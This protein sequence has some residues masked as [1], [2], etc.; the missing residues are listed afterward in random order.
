MAV[1]H[2]ISKFYALVDININVSRERRQ[3]IFKAAKIKILIFIKCL[4]RAL[5]TSQILNLYNNSVFSI[6]QVIPSYFII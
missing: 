6:G 4:L 3:H 2:N 1:Q 5:S